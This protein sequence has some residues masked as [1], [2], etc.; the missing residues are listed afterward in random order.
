MPV[1]RIESRWL[2]LMPMLEYLY[3]GGMPE[4]VR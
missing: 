4:A 3:N 2:G 1:G